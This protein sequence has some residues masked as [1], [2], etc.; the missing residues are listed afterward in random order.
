MRGVSLVRLQRTLQLFGAELGVPFG[1][2]HKACEVLDVVATDEGRRQY[3]NEAGNGAHSQWLGL[4]IELDAVVIEAILFVPKTSTAEAIDRVRDG[5]KVLQK[6]RCH[7]LIY[8]LVACQLERH[9][10]HVHTVKS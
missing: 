2:L 10:Q 9:R 4:A 3:R 1:A 5:A 7:V 8:I 6:L